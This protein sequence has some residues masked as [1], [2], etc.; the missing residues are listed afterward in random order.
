MERPKLTRRRFITQSGAAAAGALL[1][2]CS[3]QPTAVP[4]QAG[5]QATSAAPQPTATAVPSSP[6]PVAEATTIRHW[7]IWGG[8]PASTWLEAALK[9]FEDANPLIKVETTYVGGSG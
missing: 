7:H 8:P 9:E 1:A 5:T 2:A 3:S 6:V 4:T